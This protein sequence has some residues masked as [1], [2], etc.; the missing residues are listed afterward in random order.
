MKY[1]ASHPCTG[2]GQL[3]SREGDYAIF[4]GHMARLNL[5]RWKQASLRPAW[6]CQRCTHFWWAT[7]AP[8]FWCDR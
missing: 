4:R 7:S 8:S 3:P 5:K 1:L 6:E 2:V